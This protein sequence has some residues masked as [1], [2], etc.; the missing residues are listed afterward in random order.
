MLVYNVTVKIDQSVES[1]W[2][3]WMKNKHVPDVMQTGKFVN[4]RISKIDKV[5]EADGTG[6]YSFQYLCSHRSL[7]DE[8]FAEHANALRDDVISKYGNL[9]IAFRT[10]MEIVHEGEV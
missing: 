3:E 10:V 9:F 8:Y 5:E 6:T 2:L 7:L 4:F 1:E